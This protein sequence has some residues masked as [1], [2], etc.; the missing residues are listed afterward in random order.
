MTVHQRLPFLALLLALRSLLAVEVSGDMV[1]LDLGCPGSRGQR[2]WIGWDVGRGERWD[3]QGPFRIRVE[4]TAFD[5][6]GFTVGIGPK[7]AIGY[8][9]GPACRGALAHLIEE[10]VFARAANPLVITLS[11]LEAGTYRLITWHNDSRGYRPRPLEMFVTDAKRTDALVVTGREQTGSTDSAD[12]AQVALLVTA[13]GDAD[14]TV[15]IRAS[16]APRNHACLNALEIIGGRAVRQAFRPQPADGARNVSVSAALGWQPGADALRHDVHIGAEPGAPKLIAAA[17]VDSSWSPGRL[18]FGQTYCWRVD[19]VTQ[20]GAQKGALWSFTTQGGK[21]AAPTPHTGAVNAPTRLTLSWQPGHVGARHTL[22]LGTAPDAMSRVVGGKAEALCPV[23]GLELGRT[24]YWRVD[25]VYGAQTVAGDLWS[26]TVDAGKAK[27]PVPAHR[28]GYVELDCVLHWKSGRAGAKHNVYFGTDPDA[29]VCVATEKTEPRHDPGGMERGRTYYWRVDEVCDD[30]VVPGS[31]WEFAVADRGALRQGPARSIVGI[32]GAWTGGYEKLAKP[33]EQG[34]DAD[35]CVVGGGS[36]G[37][38]AAVA[39]ARAR[40]SVILVEREERLGGTSTQGYICVWQPGPACHIAREI[41]DRLKERPEVLSKT[42]YERTLTRTNGRG[43]T[44]EIDPFCHVVMGMLEETGR[45]RVL[46]RTSFVEAETH[47]KGG[48]VWSV[49]AVSSDGDVY[50]IRARVFIDCTGGAY[51]CQAAGCEVMLGEDAKSRFDE[52]SAPEKPKQRL[53]A[54]IL[55]YR[56]RRSDN[57]QIPPEPSTPRRGGYSFPLPSGD[58]IVNACGGMMPGWELI[59]RGYAEAMAECQRRV[60]AHWHWLQEA[61]YPKYEFASC[62]PM[63]G[64]RESYRVVGEYVLR[65]QDVLAGLK[66]QAHFD[67]IAIADHS[68]DTHGSGGARGRV[69]GPYGI[70][71]RCLVPKGGWSN[72]LVAC[73][74]AS[75]SHIAASSCRLSRTIMQLGHAAGLAAAMAAKTNCGVADVDVASIQKQLGLPPE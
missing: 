37:I 22:Y 69:A 71:Y 23:C 54:L 31:V 48:R 34:L 63:L 62:A 25:E 19:E 9:T 61:Q 43:L 14:V 4:R 57:P 47:P 16:G 27:N 33:G 3:E 26:F 58:R 75:F 66:K 13:R 6:D 21:A 72:L 29:L 50:R 7:G 20:E 39:A 51:L 67:I 59:E 15:R 42:P 65:E 10:I 44:F 52:P 73:R 18:R 49:K 32:P 35:V 41:Y 53:N 38:G 36:G 11:G 2:G 70:P 17:T 56:V 40:A 5:S 64:I 74:G 30:R 68:L 28:E 55:G 45:C 60:S 24:Y 46:L 12:A 1:R 8:R